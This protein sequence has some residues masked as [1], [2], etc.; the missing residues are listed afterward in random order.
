MKRKLLLITVT[1]SIAMSG[2]AHAGLYGVTHHSRANCINNESISW[3]AN[4]PHWFWVESV[5]IVQRSGQVKCN[6][7]SGWQ[8]TWRNAMVHYGE[9][10]SGWLVRASHFMTNNAGKPYLAETTWAID[11]SIYDGWW[12]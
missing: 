2:V 1:A 9:G 12:N 5:H 8:L 7:K 3:Q 4:Q 6:M 10:G 11:C